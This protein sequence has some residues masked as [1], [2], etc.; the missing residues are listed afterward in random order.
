VPRGG[1]S[2]ATQGQIER[3]D[4]HVYQAPAGGQRGTGGSPDEAGGGA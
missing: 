3:W 4:D 1:Q 2:T